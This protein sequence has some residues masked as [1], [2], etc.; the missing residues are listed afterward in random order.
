MGFFDKIK[1]LVGGHGVSVFITEIEGKAPSETEFALLDSVL[2]GRI[3]VH[4][5][6]EVEILSHGFKLIAILEDEGLYRTA[7]IAE[8][9]NEGVRF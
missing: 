1:N 5:T 2:K 6:K 8:E 3:E 9:I 4:A 7:D